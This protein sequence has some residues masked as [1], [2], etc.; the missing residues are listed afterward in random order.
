MK[1]EF[2]INHSIEILERTPEVL[3]KL[4]NGLSPEWTGN[5]EGGESWSPYDIVGH[6]VH[7]ERA[8]WIQ[9]L[10]IILSENAVRKFTSFD[11]F[12]QFQ[13]S[14]GK[15][16]QEIIEEFSQ[17]RMENIRKLKSRNIQVADLNRT[18][19]HPAFGEVILKNL[20]A[21]WVVHDLD[22]LSQIARVMAHQYR[23]EVGPWKEY[24]RILK[25]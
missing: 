4:L 17:L 10:D 2:S 6:L 1:L 3:S 13:E 23:E 16:L 15:S 24:L 25:N 14:V 12:A 9:R 11:R 22:H 19:I 7:G 21:T 20:L 8:D 18:A 5:N